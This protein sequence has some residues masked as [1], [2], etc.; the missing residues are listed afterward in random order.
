MVTAA[1]I[2][3]ASL[4]SAGLDLSEVRDVVGYASGYALLPGAGVSSGTASDSS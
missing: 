4:A 1:S 3:I 2:S